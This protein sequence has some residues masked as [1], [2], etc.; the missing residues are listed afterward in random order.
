MGVGAYTPIGQEMVRLAH[1]TRRTLEEDRRRRRAEIRDI[2][3]EVNKVTGRNT[4]SV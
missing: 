4:E 1:N 3:L 2:L